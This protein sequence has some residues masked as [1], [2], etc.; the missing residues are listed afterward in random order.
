M[1]FENWYTLPLLLLKRPIVI[2][3]RN[4]CQFKVRS[5]MDVWIVKETCLDRDYESNNVQ[6]QNGWTVVDV[7]AGIGDFAIFV[8]HE[9]PKSKVF[10]FEP[11]EESYTLLE[12]NITLNSVKNVIPFPMAIGTKSEDMTL[13]TTG[14]AVQHTTTNSL[15]TEGNALAVNVQ[16]ISLD[17]VFQMAGITSCNLLKIDCEGCEFDI[18]LNADEATL[19]KI[20]HIALEYHD[21]FTQFCHLDLEKHLKYHGFQIEMIPNPVHGYLGFMYAYR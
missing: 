17:D 12:E 20:E 14:E 3:L 6:I 9:H 1:Q 2:R 15:M 11:F 16:G 19:R 4:G 10:A 8:A 7:G 21:G 5:F 13:F 18:L